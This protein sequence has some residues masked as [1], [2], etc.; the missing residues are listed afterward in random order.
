M[1][2]RTVV[3]FAFLAIAS[4]ARA[5]VKVL[6]ELVP[7]NPGPYAVGESLS[8][9]VW[10][11]SEVSFDSYLWV[12]QLDFSDS[13]VQ[14]VLDPTFTF[15]LSSSMFPEE[16]REVY[17]ELPIP[18]AANTAEYICPECRLQLPAGGAIHIGS[19]GVN[20]PDEAATYRLDVLNVD[21]PDENHGAWVLESGSRSWRAFTG[22]ITGGTF[23][24]VVI[25]PVIP[26]VSQWG[27]IAMG[28]SLLVLGC[29]MI[30]RRTP[31]AK[32][33]RSLATQ[34]TGR[35]S[36]CHAALR[37]HAPLFGLICAGGVFLGS[38]NNAKGQ[39]ALV[40]P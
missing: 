23:D 9:D 13:D 25:A 12:V 4:L 35:R 17:P 40:T 21:D 6:V 18:S 16:F 27:I 24:F 15:D 7:D 10:L 30:H 32:G 8:V 3:A 26:T 37:S 28:L 29:L 31:G 39:S 33:G 20:L 5:E 2:A 38:G 19:I 34:G 22:E 36:V 11:H 1:S 14:L